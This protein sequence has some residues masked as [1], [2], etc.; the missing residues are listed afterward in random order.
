[1]QIKTSAKNR[2]QSRRIQS[3]R[4]ADAAALSE[5]AMRSKAFW[6][7]DEE[8]MS[9]CRSELTWTPEQISASRFDFHVCRFDNEP[10]AFYALERINSDVAELEALFVEPQHIGS[11]IGRLMIEHAKARAASQGF[12]RMIIQGDPHADSFYRAAGAQQCG[13]RPSCS[14]PGRQLPLY[15]LT[16]DIRKDDTGNGK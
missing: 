10:V 3:A 11:G 15:E 12:I 9:Q 5:L 16:L 1:M 8:F 6:G 4:S 13:S 2:H 7:Y 14:I